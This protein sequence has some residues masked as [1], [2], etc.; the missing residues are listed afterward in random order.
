[1][2]IENR[3]LNI[4]LCFCVP[5]LSQFSSYFFTLQNRLTWSTIRSSIK[6]D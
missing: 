2:E 5:A 3:E 1:M 4:A 6:A